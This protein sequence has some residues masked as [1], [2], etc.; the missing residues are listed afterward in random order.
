MLRDQL[1]ALPRRDVP[2]TSTTTSSHGRRVRRTIKALTA[3]EWIDFPGAAQV[4]QIRRTRTVKGR[5]HVEVV[6]LICSLPM[7]AAP[8]A[9]A[10]AWIQGHWFIENKLHWVRDVVFDEDH[11]QLRTGPGPHVKASLR[12]TAISLIRL[13]GH[14]KTASRLRH[15]ARDSP[16]PNELLTLT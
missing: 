10:A 11:H 1:R 14:T 12:N 6:Y 8:P 9:M 2:A 7:T 16:R 4:L 5:K 3:P 13:T 15:H